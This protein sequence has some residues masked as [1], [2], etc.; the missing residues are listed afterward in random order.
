M[1]GNGAVMKAR[2]LMEGADKME[3]DNNDKLED[4]NNNT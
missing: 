2:I 1:Q 4:V 3:D